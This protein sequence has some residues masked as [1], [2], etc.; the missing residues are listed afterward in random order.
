[1][2][3]SSCIRQRMPMAEPAGDMPLLR[4]VPA[5]GMTSPKQHM[6]GLLNAIKFGNEAERLDA[7]KRLEETADAS[8]S[9]ILLDE[10]R[11]RNPETQLICAKALANLADAR[12][13]PVL[14]GL[15]GQGHPYGFDLFVFLAGFGDSRAVP[16][17][18]KML[19][20]D[21]S[22]FR[23]AAAEGLGKA[24][25]ASSANRLIGM[26]KDK[27]APVRNKAAL[28]LGIL[29][30][31]DAALPLVLALED[32]SD[33]VRA[34]AISALG[35]LGEPAIPFLFD[36][37]VFGNPDYHLQYMESFVAMGGTAVPSLI[38]ALDHPD[39]TLRSYAARSLGNIGDHR[40]EAALLRA[41]K[42]KHPAVRGD[43]ANALRMMEV[44]S[45]LPVLKELAGNDPNEFVR[46]ASEAAIRS[47][48][49]Q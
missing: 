26:L 43:A 18:E 3:L 25:S 1:M 41:L 9:A 21:D 28:A 36:A 46:A 2:A 10:L 45:A 14:I 30:P 20:S 6:R 23:A 7:S 15:A 39:N 24:G 5:S 22:A 49:G 4:L 31:P 29:K 11:G 12:A 34:S 35:K 47:I 13:V 33:Y 40:A 48:S 44:S 8:V 16:L 42:D 27:E 19:E 38:D 37:I 17:M 32:K